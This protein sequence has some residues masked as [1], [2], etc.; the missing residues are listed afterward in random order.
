MNFFLAYPAPA[1][2]QKGA[3]GQMASNS[4]AATT[5]YISSVLPRG[6]DLRAAW[7]K[8]RASAKRKREDADDDLDA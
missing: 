6:L 4:G 5:P 7:A 8:S 3:A 2:R 1:Q